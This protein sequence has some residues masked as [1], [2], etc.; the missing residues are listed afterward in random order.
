MTDPLFRA[1][2]QEIS[3]LRQLRQTVLDILSDDRTTR[4]E[5]LRAIEDAFEA[6]HDLDEEMEEIRD[7]ER[8]S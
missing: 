5:K 7:R 1:L 6:E 4:E 3:H 2:E 8:L